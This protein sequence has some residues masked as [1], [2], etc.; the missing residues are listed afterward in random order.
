MPD[1]L[2][3]DAEKI[4]REKVARLAELADDDPG[5]AREFL[6]GKF[7]LFC[8][9]VTYRWLEPKP[10]PW[11]PVADHAM[12]WH[13]H[14]HEGDYSPMILAG[15][16]HTK[17]TWVL[18]ELLYHLQYIDHFRALYWCNNVENQ[19]TS[20]MNELEELIDANLWLD[21]LHKG[22][23]DNQ[24]NVPAGVKEKN[25]PNGSTLYGTAVGA[26]AEGDH[27]NMV[28]GDDPL[29]E[30]GDIPDKQI[31]DFYQK[32]I[33]PM[34]DTS[35]LSTI[36]GTRK[37]PKDIYHLLLQVVDDMDEFDLE[38]YRLLE[39]P[40]VKEAWDRKYGDRPDHLAARDPE[41][42]HEYTE[43]VAPDLAAALGLDGDTVSVLWDHARGPDFLLGKLA[44]QGKPSFMREFCMVFTHVEDAI[45]K[46]SLIE[47]YPVGR[48]GPPP[49]SRVEAEAEYG[50]DL[51]KVAIG[52]D[53]AV[54]EGSDYA[55]WVVL[56]VDADETRHVLHV[57]YADGL[58]PKRI[59]KTT[60]D[61]D[62]QYS[63][64][65]IVWESNGW[66]E[67]LAEEQVE[68]PSHLPM[69]MAGTTKRKHSWTEGVPRLAGR[70]EDAEYRFYLDDDT[71]EDLVDALCSLRMDDNDHL[72]GHTPDLVMAQY[73]A[74][75]GLTQRG[76][77]SSRTTTGASERERE[78]KEQAREKR[79]EL[80]GNPVGDAIV[81]AQEE[82]QSGNP[83]Y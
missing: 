23:P 2:A 79:D 44:R 45:I 27:V 74:E 4:T 57:S 16:K 28:V 35:D 47:D 13:R 14:L 29:K 39:Y 68:F 33:V 41:S 73:M 6:H 71:T 19:L 52:I 64:E 24:N 11:A 55:A 50:I 67:W 34:A 53:P 51:E 30:L 17:T 25:F 70:I 49:S 83:Y 9:V 36:V 77:S 7:R 1:T 10:E 21:N 32:V 62:N 48:N 72:A 82:A 18:C 61:L 15:R 75:K 40:A 12:D 46:R 54:V 26:G 59:R 5:L 42:V 58:S 56:G 38:G 76:L 22:K 80:E 69:E 37:R 31:V 43:K 65:I 81:S 78:R 20:R 63:P 8:N 60:V 3:V 66:Q